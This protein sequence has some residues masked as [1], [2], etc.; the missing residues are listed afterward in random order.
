MKIKSNFKRLIL[1]LIG[2]GVLV[3]LASIITYLI[4]NMYLENKGI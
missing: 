2:S 4:F 1:I 3:A